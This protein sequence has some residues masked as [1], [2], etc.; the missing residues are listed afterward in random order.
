M[1]KKN[2]KQMP[3]NPANVDHP[4]AKILEGISRFLDDKPIITDMVFQD[5]TKGRIL[6]RTG[7][8]G[9]T[10]EQVLRAAIVKQLEGFAY[11][12]LAFHLIDSTCYRNFCR[13]PFSHKG[14][15]KSAL[16]KNIK[17]ISGETWEAINNILI[18]N[19]RDKGI[20]KGRESRIDCT[21]VVSHNILLEEGWEFSQTLDWMGGNIELF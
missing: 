7:A 1:H 8:D 15:K 3:L 13:I 21:V 10:A 2:Q 4:H 14:F 18:G 9:M 17:S 11:E 12:A 19:A 5:L 6:K 20:E 16:G